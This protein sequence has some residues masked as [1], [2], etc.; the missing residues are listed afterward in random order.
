MDSRLLLL[1]AVL[2]CSVSYTYAAATLV[3]ATTGTSSV[4]SANLLEGGASGVA[5][6]IFVKNGGTAGSDDIA[7]AANNFAISGLKCYETDGTTEVTGA[8]TAT[9]TVT[10][11]AGSALVG[12]A[13]LELIGT[14][15]Y[16]A[17]TAANCVKIKSCKATVASTTPSL[18]FDADTVT[19]TGC[20]APAVVAVDASP[21]PAVKLSG[22]A[23]TSLTMATQAITAEFT[24]SNGAA[25]GAIAAVTGA[26]KNF[27]VAFAC[28]A[29]TGAAFTPTAAT[30]VSLPAATEVSA[31]AASG[32]LAVVA[33]VNTGGFS[34][35]DCAAMTKCTASVS[36]GTGASNAFTAATHDFT[37]TCGGFTSTASLVLM[38]VCALVALRH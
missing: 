34:A 9:F 17:I 33:T 24:I 1:A 35:T 37:L 6:N 22:S 15:S 26:N 30:T 29:A 12:A 2:A 13:E 38:L 10:T 31:L 19:I 8:V 32:T 28:S 20:L 4:G 18:T 3:A 21:A 11:G 36:A 16:T 27:A 14:F 7:A 25:G 5:F 23:I